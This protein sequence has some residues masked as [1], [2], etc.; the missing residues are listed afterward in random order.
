[1]RLRRMILQW[2][3]PSTIELSFVR[4]RNRPFPFGSDMIWAVLPG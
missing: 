1:M 3:G 2:L 4:A